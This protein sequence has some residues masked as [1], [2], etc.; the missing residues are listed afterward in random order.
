MKSLSAVAITLVAFAAAPALGQRTVP[1]GPTCSDVL[2]IDVHGQ[3]VIGDY[4]SG[5]GHDQLGWPPSGRD[6]SETVGANRGV[7]VRGGPGPG[8]H[9]DNEVAPG[10]SLC[11]DSQ[12]PG[13][14][15]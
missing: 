4:A 2:D 1:S 8:Y 10:A 9:F 14:H 13:A 7:V 3:H 6:I 15:Y 12:S 11:T 5:T